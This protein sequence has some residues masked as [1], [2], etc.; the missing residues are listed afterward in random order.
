[1]AFGHPTDPIGALGAA[2]P[3]TAC[4]K[5]SEESDSDDR[6]G[7]WVFKS[8]RVCSP[9]KFPQAV[10][11][12]ACICEPQQLHALNVYPLT[13]RMGLAGSHRCRGGSVAGCSRR[14]MNASYPTNA[15]LWVLCLAVCAA[16]ATRR[17]EAPIAREKAPQYC[18]GSMRRRCH[19]R[20]ALVPCPHAPCPAPSSSHD[21]VCAQMRSTSRQDELHSNYHQFLSCMSGSPVPLLLVHACRST[22]AKIVRGIANGA[23]R[24]F[25]EEREAMLQVSPQRWA[26]PSGLSATTVPL[27]AWL[28][29]LKSPQS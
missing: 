13:H 3:P 26:A 11:P 22:L 6:S 20:A 25:C 2:A 14:K 10:A 18:A 8:P 29:I 16:T 15:V 24:R 28:T 21:I 9:M 1:M 12:L 5:M 23:V 4:S 19:M 27:H 17:G 7:R